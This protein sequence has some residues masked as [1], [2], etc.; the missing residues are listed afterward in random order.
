[1]SNG[2][3]A[4]QFGGVAYIHSVQ[5]DITGIAEY[6]LKLKELLSR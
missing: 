4:K 6:I 5:L 3:S 2:F 1:M